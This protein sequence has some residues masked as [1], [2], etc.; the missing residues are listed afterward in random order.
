MVIAAESL[1]IGAVLLGSILN[2][3]DELVDLLNLPELVVP[4][5]GIPLGYPDQEPQM[6]PRM[7]KELIHF[8][9]ENPE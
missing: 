5:L 2:Q 4:V 7:P 6:K 8:E 1:G 3:V 9:N